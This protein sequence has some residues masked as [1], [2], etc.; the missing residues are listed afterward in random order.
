[1]SAGVKLIIVF[2]AGLTFGLVVGLM[3]NPASAEPVGKA[4]A[5]M[6]SGFS[7]FGLFLAVVI[8]LGIIVSPDGGRIP[9]E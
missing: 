3:M 8:V 1:M 2:L 4:V 5:G 6:I 9:K 7:A